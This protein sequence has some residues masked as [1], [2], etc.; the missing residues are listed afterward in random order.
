M[1]LA[2]DQGKAYTAALEKMKEDD[3][4]ASQEVEDYIISLACEDAEGMYMYDSSGK[5]A[6]MIPEEGDNQHVEV[7]VQDIED[8]RF[9]PGSL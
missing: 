8:K 4:H 7:V 2:D 5:L 6:W 3:V 9:L 1:Q